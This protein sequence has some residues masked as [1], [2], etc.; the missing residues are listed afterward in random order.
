MYP[1]CMQGGAYWVAWEAADQMRGVLLQAWEEGGGRE[2]EGGGRGSGGEGGG[3]VGGDGGGGRGE[4]G[5]GREG[6]GQTQHDIGC[7]L[8]VL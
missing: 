4:G 1:D 7:I 8:G 5:G 3:G 2:G 6:E